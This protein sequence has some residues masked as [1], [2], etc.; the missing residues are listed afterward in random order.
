VT[1]TLAEA[2]AL[3]IGA[4]ALLARVGAYYHDLGKGRD[5]SWFSENQREPNRHLDLAPARSATLIRQHV[6][7]GVEA[8][9]RW[10]LP[11]PVVDIVAQHHG[12]R[13][14]SF[15][16]SKAARA[17]GEV[18]PE[19]DAA[20]RYPGPKPQTREAALVMIADACEASARD[21]LDLVGA[22]VL[23]L[24]RRRVAEIVDEGQLDES[25]MTLSDLEAA[26]RA[27]AAALE[28]AHRGRAEPPA[29]GAL[30]LVRP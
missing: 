11:R 25:D 15:F 3:A 9:R 13:L 20:F 5:P 17:P 14:V 19:A 18:P 6:L 12:T 8:A 21:Q 29:A 26:S 27:M 1:G 24:V 28:A 23:A 4:D 10:R 2:G 16:W 22:R 30:Q 7:D